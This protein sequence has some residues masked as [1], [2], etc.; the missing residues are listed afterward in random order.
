MTDELE[1]ARA[2][3][4]DARRALIVAGKAYDAARAA[5]RVAADAYD[6]ALDAAEERTEP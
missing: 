4:D 2:R 1:G 5:H 6:A 3:Y